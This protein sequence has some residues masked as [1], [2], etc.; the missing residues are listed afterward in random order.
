[1]AV[2]S[3]THFPRPHEVRI[4]RLL[5]TIEDRVVIEKILTHLGLPIEVPQPAPARH[6]MLGGGAGQRA[7]FDD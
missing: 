1:M 7:W 5:A 4:I 6:E 2:P 3:T